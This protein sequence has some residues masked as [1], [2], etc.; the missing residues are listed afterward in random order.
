M[1]PSFV[2]HFKETQMNI[3]DV[4]IGEPFYCVFALGKQ[5]FIE[6]CIPTSLPY[7]KQ[8]SENYSSTFVKVEIETEYGVRKDDVSLSDRGIIPNTYNNHQSF[9]SE[10]VAKQHLKFAKKLPYTAPDIPYLY[11]HDMY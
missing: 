11:L 2:I 3:N 7:T 10:K 5:S 8:I 6:K 4:K 1:W 9:I